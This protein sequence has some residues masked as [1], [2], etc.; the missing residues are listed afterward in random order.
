ME[1]E[2]EKYILLVDV[3]VY[4]SS[5]KAKAGEGSTRD[6]KA[7]E[8]FVYNKANGMI[9]IT[10]TSGSPGGWINP[11]DNVKKEEPVEE[12]ET[13]VEEDKEEKPV[14]IQEPDLIENKEKTWKDY[15]IGLLQKL[16]VFKR[17][18]KTSLSG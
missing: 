7:G 1:V 16:L 17:I 2:V 12:V 9:N 10:K 4:T 18:I 3:P 13:P 5:A 15:L 6:Y 11:K 8:Y 14:E